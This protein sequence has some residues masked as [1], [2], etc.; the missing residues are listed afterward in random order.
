MEMDTTKMEIGKI[1]T[2]IKKIKNNVIIITS[3]KMNQAQ[4]KL[5]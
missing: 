2:E 5:G 1:K 3:V 4:S